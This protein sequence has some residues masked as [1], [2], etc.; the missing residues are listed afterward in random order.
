MKVAI[1][2]DFHFGYSRFYEDSFVQA[3]RA[4]LEADKRADLILVAGDV[5]DTR[6]PKPEVMSRAISIFKKLTKPVYMIHGTHERRPKGFVNPVEL[7]CQIGLAKNVHGRNV[8]FEKDGDRVAVYGLGGVP[9]EYAK[10]AIESLKPKPLE[11]AFNV[12]MFHQNIKEFMEMVEHGLYMDDLPPGFDLY[13]DGHLHKFHHLVK[14]GK[15]LIIPGSTLLTQIKREETDKGFVL[16]DTRDKTFEFIKIETRPFYYVEAHSKEEAVS[17][18]S[19]IDML[20]KPIVALE[21]HFNADES[22]KSRIKAY[23]DHC[24]L[25]VN[26]K[27][28]DD[29]DSNSWESTMLPE[30]SSIREVANE[31]L[32]K[33][34]KR[35][36][37]KGG[38]LEA[39]L[40]A[41][42]EGDL[43]KYISLFEEEVKPLEE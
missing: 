37:L 13:I 43:E 29:E 22:F 35:R 8:V 27:T 26:Y 12:F 41:A 21:L 17:K 2:G 18:L 36:K 42:E 15:E 32:S 6:V 5:F 23:E 10:A 16:Y 39:L 24:Y 7:L 4:L 9:E 28:K 19:A 20:K 1:L 38:D 14:G 30:S 40:T 3:E 33:S 11:N 25:F 34:L 31:L